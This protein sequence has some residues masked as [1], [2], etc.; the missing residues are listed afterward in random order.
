[1]LNRFIIV[2]LSFILFSCSGSKLVTGS[3]KNHIEFSYNLV[4][5]DVKDMKVDGKIIIDNDFTYCQA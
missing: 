4:V 3:K 1:M 2:F 5:H